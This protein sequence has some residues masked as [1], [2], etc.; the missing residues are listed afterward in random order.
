MTVVDL[1]FVCER[2]PEHPD[3]EPRSWQAKGQERIMDS[4]TQELTP[5]VISSDATCPECGNTGVADYAEA[6]VYVIPEDDSFRDQVEQ[7][8]AAIEEAP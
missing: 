6:T 3:G 2:L 8:R 4:L 7:I 1:T 5:V